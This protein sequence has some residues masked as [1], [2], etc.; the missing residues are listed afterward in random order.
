MDL[1]H[2]QGQDDLL[3]EVY[4]R[5]LQEN[6]KGIGQAENCV[7][8]IYAPFTH[9]DLSAHMGKLLRHPEMH[10]EVTIVFQTVENLHRACPNDL[11]DWY[12]T[13]NYPTPGGNVVANRAFINYMEGRKERAY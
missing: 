7:K 8:A 4:H 10:A 9:Q 5:C 6:A 2:L 13:G 1:L 12:F 3:Q 11:G